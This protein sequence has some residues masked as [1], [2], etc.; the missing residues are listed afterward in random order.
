MLRRLFENTNNLSL[1]ESFIVAWK[2]NYAQ[3]QLEK[4]AIRIWKNLLNNVCGYDYYERNGSDAW[5]KFIV[6]SKVEDEEFLANLNSQQAT[7]KTSNKKSNEQNLVDETTDS[8]GKQ[9]VNVSKR[10]KL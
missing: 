8:D 6:K 7:F 2:T 4:S 9:N 5:K 3:L 1:K 10:I